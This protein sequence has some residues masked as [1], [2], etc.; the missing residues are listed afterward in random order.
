MADREHTSRDRRGGRPDLPAAGIGDGWSGFRHV[1]ALCPPSGRDRRPTALT[2]APSGGAPQIRAMRESD[3]EQVLEIENLAFASPWTLDNFR[4]ELLRNPWSVN[5][6]VEIDQQIVAYS[7]FWC[8]S[9]EV[10]INNIAVHPDHRRR[11]LAR[12]LVEDVLTTAR[13]KGAERVIL[14]VRPTNVEALALYRSFGFQEVG[15]RPNYYREENEDAIVMEREIK[16]E[17]HQ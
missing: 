17:P 9:G 10:A 16:K 12:L 2:V 1:T 11:G 14:E 5:Q 8:V 6:V 7:T 4:G 15:R 13:A 3:L